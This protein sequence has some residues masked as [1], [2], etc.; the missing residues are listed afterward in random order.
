MDHQGSYNTKISHR[1][2]KLV[3]VMNLRFK[4]KVLQADH[5]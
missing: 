4:E 5:D 2:K 1:L 3:K